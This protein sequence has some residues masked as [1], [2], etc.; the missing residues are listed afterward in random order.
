MIEGAERTRDIVDALKRFSAL[1]KSTPERV[2]LNDVVERSVRW[3]A[4]SAPT[5]F[6]VSVDLPR[7]S[8]APATP[9]SCSRWS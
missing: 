1:D 5:R 9:A 8:A 4:Q 2:S 3:V 6:T 7:T